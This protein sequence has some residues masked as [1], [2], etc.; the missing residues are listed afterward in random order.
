MPSKGRP[1]REYLGAAEVGLGLQTVTPGGG[2][3]LISGGGERE[4][5]GPEGQEGKREMEESDEVAE[6]TECRGGR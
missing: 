3:R 1:G 6:G 5:G 2:R 4:K